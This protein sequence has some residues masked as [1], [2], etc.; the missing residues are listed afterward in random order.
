MTR[1]ATIQEPIKRVHDSHHKHHCLYVQ[2]HQVL[3][4]SP[5][6]TETTDWYQVS[7]VTDETREV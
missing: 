5:K 7:L 2:D 3:I 4:P 1:R 6:E